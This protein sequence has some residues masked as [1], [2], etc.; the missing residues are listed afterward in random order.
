[1]HHTPQGPRSGVFGEDQIGYENPPQLKQ[2]AQIE[3]D[4]REAERGQQLQEAKQKVLSIQRDLM[5]QGLSKKEAEEEAKKI[6]EEEHW[7]QRKGLKTNERK[8][9]PEMYQ[10]RIRKGRGSENRHWGERY[11]QE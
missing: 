7:A 8:E 6:V 9:L 10:E 3:E 5:R 11:G 2:F 1:M 4:I